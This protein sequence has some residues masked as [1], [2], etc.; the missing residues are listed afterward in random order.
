MKRQIL[1]L[2]VLFCVNFSYAQNESDALRYSF[3]NYSGTSR[4]MGTGGALSSLGADISAISLNPGGIGRYSK[5]DFNFTT[6]ITS[7]NT[8][9]TYNNEFSADNRL[10]FNISNAGGVL[11]A[12][13]RN[14]SQ[15]RNFQFGYTYNRT[16]DFQSNDIIKGNHNNSMID[17]FTEWA[18]GIDPNSL[19]DNASFDAG[20]A[21][22]TGLIG[23]D[24]LSSQ[25]FAW[26]GT[27]N[28][29]QTMTR[30]RR[31]AQYASDLIFGSNYADV[32]YVGGSLGFPSVRYNETSTLNE[33]FNG[34]TTGLDSYNY[35]YN[36][37]TR[38][39][40]FNMKLGVIIKP[41]NQV[42]I[43]LA[44]HSPTWYSMSDRYNS[45]I[46]SY[47]T[48]G[49]S[50]NDFSKEGFYEYR[51]RT[52]A[53]FI[54]DLGVVLG[55]RG[56]VSAQYEYV[57]Y[58]QA[59]LNHAANSIDN[60]SFSN[61][62]STIEA[63]YQSA[64]NMRIGGEFRVTNHWSVRGGFALYGSPIKSD[65]IS[66]D[67]SRTNYSG[68]F[69]YRNATFYLDFAYVLSKWSENYYLYDPNITDAAK[70]DYSLSN[71]MVTAGFRF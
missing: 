63:N 56:F 29:D 35:V 27:D 21:Y 13:L 67:A 71:F 2:V 9:A 54:G 66:F 44:I 22:N 33:V 52:P 11:V 25:Y 18:Q 38:G 30:E 4:F 65:V 48:N 61:E 14:G 68:G 28:I 1:V 23:Y 43:G 19:Y 60:Y 32:L 55:K 51:L 15:W 39:S 24:S 12:P 10:N 5:S 37:R 26:Y 62:N 53:R 69:G 45:E 59:K 36:V 34:D 20:L 50:Y 49:D 41:I 47:L 46:T 7:T 6:N 58:T 42:R 16:N 8:G 31:G 57:D 64:S 70:L 3:L 17:V 40:G